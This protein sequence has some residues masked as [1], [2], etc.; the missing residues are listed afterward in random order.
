MKWKIVLLT[1]LFMAVSSV[2][3]AQPNTKAIAP[4]EESRMAFDGEGLT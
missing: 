4:N 3:L 2:V 1:A